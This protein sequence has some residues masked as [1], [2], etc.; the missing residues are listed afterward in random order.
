[1]PEFSMV[2]L[3]L[4]AGLVGLLS[5]FVPPVIR[6]GVELDPGAVTAGALA[7]LIP[8]FDEGPLALVVVV[9][10]VMVAASRTVEIAVEVRVGVVVV[11]GLLAVSDG[12]RFAD[13]W[14]E[15]VSVAAVLLVVYLAVPAVEAF[16][17]RAAAPMLAWS[18]LSMYVTVPDTEEV[19][20]VASGL[21]V[22]AAVAVLTDAK[23]HAPGL[24]GLG[25]LL[26]WAATYGARGREASV[27]AVLCVAVLLWGPVFVAYGRRV[28]W[29]STWGRVLAGVHVV[30]AL[31]IAR[32]AGIRD[33][34]MEVAVITVVI[35]AV[36]A[37][38]VPFLV[39]RSPLR[40]QRLRAEV[41]AE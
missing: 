29:K 9:A 21:V 38:V 16:G 35:L 37:L 40:T 39:W 24:A 25:A 1:M 12:H 15:W 30:V 26:V 36:M 41:S 20:I 13:W 33:D 34:R 31:A 7:V 27:V 5:K 3:G 10:L 8:M 14:F 18:G 23:I 19:T 4:A 2:V 22:V 6:R 28:H 17:G 32:G 11:A